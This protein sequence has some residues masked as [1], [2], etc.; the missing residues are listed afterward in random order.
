MAQRRTAKQRAALRKAQLASAR[1]RR[2]NRN[3]AIGAAGVAVGIG[4][5]VAGAK[6]GHKIKLPKRSS[7]STE[8]RI[9]G[10]LALPPGRS[11]SRPK[12]AIRRPR[13]FNRKG[14]F[15]AGVKGIT[16]IKRQRGSY[17]LKRRTEYT[18]KPR[19]AKYKKA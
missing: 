6:H 18:H 12:K 17:D 15:K 1:K 5:G 11:A 7:R 3:I 19:P 10:M 4:I 2:R 9:N 8:F 16:Y 13:P 14:V